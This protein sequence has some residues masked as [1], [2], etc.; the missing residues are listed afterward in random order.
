MVPG[1]RQRGGGGGEEREGEGERQDYLLGEHSCLIY[2]LVGV[3][4]TPTCW[5]GSPLELCPLPHICAFGVPAPTLASKDAE[6]LRVAGSKGPSVP[7]C[8]QVGGCPLHL[9]T[10][11]PPPYTGVRGECPGCGAAGGLLDTAPPATCFCTAH[12]LRMFFTCLN[13]WKKSKEE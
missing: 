1:W 10:P 9:A 12:K 6:V 8:P 3:G 4:H 5:V 7:G 11:S 13:S 2:D